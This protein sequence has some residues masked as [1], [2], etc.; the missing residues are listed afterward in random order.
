MCEMRVEAA[1]SARTWSNLRAAALQVSTCAAAECWRRRPSAVGASELRRK[2]DPGSAGRG[3]GGGD[4]ARRAHLGGDGLVAG[5]EA[6]GLGAA[7]VA[8]VVEINEV[9]VKHLH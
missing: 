9:L 4:R 5:G 1:S 8:G 7:D 3:L 6:H 2:P